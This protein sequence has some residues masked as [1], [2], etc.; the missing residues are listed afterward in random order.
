MSVMTEVSWGELIDKYTILEIKSERINDPA[1]LK[2]VRIELECISPIK[3]RAHNLSS[4]L[5]EMEARLKAIN[6]ELWDI[7][8]RIRECEQ[9]KDFGPGVRGTGQVRLFPQ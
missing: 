5:E 4:V 7:E 6:E 9:V 8:D 3:A 1:K 2:N